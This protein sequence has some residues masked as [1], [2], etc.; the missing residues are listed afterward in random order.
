VLS[1]FSNLTFQGKHFVS[2]YSFIFR[3]TAR[4]ATLNEFIV[5]PKK[6][7][8]HQRQHNHRQQTSNI[9]DNDLVREMRQKLKGKNLRDIII[10]GAN[11]GR[12][13]VFNFK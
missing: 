11:I 9:N 10:D 1:E 6:Q 3:P 12:T 13:Y 7:N 5:K 8:T 4:E 2:C